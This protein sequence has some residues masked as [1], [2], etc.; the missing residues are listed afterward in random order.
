[1]KQ[2]DAQHM[3]NHYYYRQLDPRLIRKPIVIT[4][5]STST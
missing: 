1:M 2:I 3:L 5:T 4:S